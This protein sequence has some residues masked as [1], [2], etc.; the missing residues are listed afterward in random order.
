MSGAALSLVENLNDFFRAKNYTRIEPPVLQPTGVFTE[1][2]GEDIRRRLFV[3]QDR[4]GHDLCLRPEYTIPV[5]LE[6]LK[7]TAEPSGAF[8]YLGPVFRSRSDGPGEFLQAG[9]ES[10]GRVDR[11][12]ADAECVVHALKALSYMDVTHSSVVF[13]DMAL[14][15]AVLNALGLTAAAVRRVVASLITGTSLES[16]D[17][18]DVSMHEKHASLLA[19]IEN[20]DSRAVTA[21]IEDVF[22]IAGVSRIGGRSVHDIAERFLA[23]ASNRSA[24]TPAQRESLSRF[25]AIRGEPDE[26]VEAVRAFAGETG[27]DIDS[28][29]SDLETR[30]GFLAALNADLSQFRFEAGFAR[31]L[32][33]YTGFIFE[34]FSPLH[35]EPVAGGGRYDS[36]FR[37]LGAGSDIPAVGCAFHL[38]RLTGG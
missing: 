30:I 34:V 15:G 16:L 12:A 22:A 5:A 13:G 3:T 4:A 29:L 24:L 23:K 37:Q 38:N 17:T 6:L 8:Y 21:F 20:Q 11:S 35:P 2:S 9:T 7:R 1:L 26:A 14:L 18:G 25:L 27:L 36:L 28:A 33:Y 19:A 31:N 10:I 32:D